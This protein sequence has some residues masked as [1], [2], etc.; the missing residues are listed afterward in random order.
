MSEKKERGAPIGFIRKTEAA[1]VMG[2]SVRAID[3]WM[4]AGLIAY[5]KF[6]GSVFFKSDELLASIEK[7]KVNRVNP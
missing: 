1:R 7:G 3:G 2:V 5:Y 6:G 4:A